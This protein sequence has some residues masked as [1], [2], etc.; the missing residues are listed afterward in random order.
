VDVSKIEDER[1]FYQAVSEYAAKV[2]DWNAHVD[3]DFENDPT[4]DEFI[5]IPE[6]R[7]EW[8]KAHKSAVYRYFRKRNGPTWVRIIDGSG[9]KR[10]T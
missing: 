8:I 9:S 6:N 10:A 2:W 4:P 3:V 7:I 5:A 1:Q